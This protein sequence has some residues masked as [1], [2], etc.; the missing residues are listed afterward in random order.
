MSDLSGRFATRLAATPF[1]LLG[2]AHLQP[3]PGSPRWGGSLRSVVDRA[4]HDARVLERAG[5]DGVVVENYG[6]APFVPSASSPETVAAMAVVVATVREA[7]PAEML[8]G[9]NLL[10]N[11]AAGALAVAMAAG[12]DLI[13]VNV[14]VG[15]AWT[16]QGLIHGRAHETMRLRARL[17]APVAVLADVMVKHAAPV[18][19]VDPTTLA[20]DA[21]DRGLADGLVVTGCATGA[22]VD[23]R[24]LQQTVDGAGD[25]PVLAGSGTT[26]DAVAQLHA[27]G[28]R[29]A[30]VGT[31][32]KVGGQ[33]EAPVDA[34]R[35]ARLVVARD[36]LSIEVTG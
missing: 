33:V 22:A 13:R 31:W 8:V 7:L 4:L 26:P 19:A 21:L 34:D 18:A 16:D 14:H 10:R 28:A 24:R 27:A 35:A 29:G 1:A 9:V 15:S 20:R 11:D 23:A 30:I 3:L 17:G 2:M 6:D 36:G 5:F 32:C 12:A 25:R